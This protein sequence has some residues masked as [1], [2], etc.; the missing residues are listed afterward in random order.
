[1]FCT[2]CGRTLQDGEI[3]S[4]QTQQRP[5]PVVASSGEDITFN[6]DIDKMKN[7]VNKVYTNVS[8][9][10]K[11]TDVNVFE[12][13]KKIV[14]ECIH[15]NEG[16]VPVKQYN[17][18]KLQSFFSLSFAEAR[19]QITNKRLLLRAAGKSVTGNTVLQN[20]FKINEI[21]GIDIRK[22]PKF[23]FP[24]LLLLLIVTALGGALGFGL[25]VLIA[26]V[27]VLAYILGILMS[28]GGTAGYIFA[29]LK[30]KSMQTYKK[31]YMIK[32]IAVSFVLGVVIGSLGQH[33]EVL[34][35]IFAL[36]LL[37]LWVINGI[38]LV[39]VPS[40]SLSVKTKD[41][42]SGIELK[43]KQFSAFAPNNGENSGFVQVMPWKDTDAAIREIGSIIE[44]LQT[45][46]D[47]AIY[48]WHR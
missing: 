36:P 12:R 33:E 17:L 34:A 14:P 10:A 39:F 45:I 37:V 31:F 16:E 44:D 46:G 29:E 23:S 27:E 20:E 9:A 25:G 22:S 42:S 32:Q 40:L 24:H 41:G 5:R 48:K 21:A 11:A 6:I 3:C 2:K 30:L 18:A 19:L 4:C 47:S 1:M 7:N 15:A 43:R 26:E 35:V 13:D 8:A 38:H 28:I